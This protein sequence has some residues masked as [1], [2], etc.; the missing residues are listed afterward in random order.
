M[1]PSQR[2]KK[3]PKITDEGWICVKG[4]YDNGVIT[5]KTP[6]IDL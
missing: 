3:K 1:L 6:N 2:F 5:C 4:N